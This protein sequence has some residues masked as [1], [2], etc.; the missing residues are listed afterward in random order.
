MKKFV[1]I[2]FI[3]V[4][5]M[6]FASIT[7][8]AYGFLNKAAVT[9]KAPVTASGLMSF[10]LEDGFEEII[11]H[12]D[13]GLADYLKISFGRHGLRSKPFLSAHTSGKFKI[14]RFIYLSYH[15]L[16]I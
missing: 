2:F 11:N 5:G 9:T 7:V 6:F 8:Y 16:L 12:L 14:T 13:S 10:E 3:A 1:A 4:I 15:K